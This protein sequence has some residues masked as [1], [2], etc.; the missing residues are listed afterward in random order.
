MTDP[1]RGA[2]VL[3]AEGSGVA[4][5][6]AVIAGSGLAGL[7]ESFHSSAI[8]DY[9]KISGMPTATVAGHPGQLHL[10]MAGGV[11]VW[12]CQGRPHFY[13]TGTME[14]VVNFIRTLMG[15]GVT[16]FV[17][18]NSAGAVDKSYR[19]GDVMIVADHLF[20]P[21]LTG[22]HPLVG[23][24]DSV[25][26]RFPDLSAA[27]D[28]GFRACIETELSNSGFTVREGI[29]AMVSGPSYETPAEVSMLRG[30]GVHA[31][32]MSTAPEVVVARH[33]GA[34]VVAVST[35]TNLAGELGDTATDH[36]AVIDIAAAGASRLGAAIA[37]FVALQGC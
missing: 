37:R 3:R 33:G 31:V 11:P 26:D 5:R 19:P 32:G 20:L 14:P 28:Q 35:I 23:P 2:E 8:L 4:P 25:G 30:L 9:S 10:A 36:G 1:S 17:F 34:A 12:V 27:Y 21:G 6:W 18:T 15:A 13:V 7:V 29:Y 16:R 24:N 22:A